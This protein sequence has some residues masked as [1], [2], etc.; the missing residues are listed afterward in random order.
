VTRCSRCDRPAVWR[1]RLRLGP[2]GATLQRHLC[3]EHAD[4]A[5]HSDVVRLVTLV[6]ATP[7]STTSERVTVAG[8]EQT[9]AAR[10][11]QARLSRSPSTA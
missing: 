6:R 4:E 7:S 2:D 1:A 10:P 8:D 3:D 11:L 9:I 5:R